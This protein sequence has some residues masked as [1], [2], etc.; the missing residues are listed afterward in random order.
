MKIG[1]YVINLARSRARWDGLSQRAYELGVTL[2]RVEGVDGAALA[3][4]ARSDLDMKHFLRENGRTVLPG[5][6][7]C[8]RSHILAVSTFLASNYD[9]AI[10]LEDDVELA[11]GLIERA[12][13]IREAM[14]DAD[15]VKLLN[16][17]TKWFRKTAT[18]RL[19]DEIGRS[20]HGPQGSAACYLITRAGAEK[21]L[22]SMQVMRY[23][24]D[25]ALERGWHTGLAVF[26]VRDNVLNLSPASKTTEIATRDDYRIGKFRGPRRTI[27]HLLRALDYIRRIRYCLS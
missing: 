9:A 4:G 24:V 3:K 21:I 22:K 7:G 16:H 1:I 14:P 15:L 23:P 10:I 17:R 11:V 2:E 8:Y 6:Y 20:I 19:G 26:T 5:E 27:T 13:A 12:I 18:S 25:V